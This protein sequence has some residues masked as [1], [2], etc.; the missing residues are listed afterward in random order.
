MSFHF[1]LI[2][3]KWGLQCRFML[4]SFNYFNWVNKMQFVKMNQHIY[5]NLNVKSEF[6]SLNFTETFIWN[7]LQRRNMLGRML[8]GRLFM[9]ILSIYLFFFCETKHVF[10]LFRMW[11]CA[12]WA[13][14]KWSHSLK[15]MKRYM[16]PKYSKSSIDRKSIFFMSLDRWLLRFAESNIRTE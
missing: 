4:W 6:F 9:P 10:F 15:C 13:R 7:L 8:Y 2:R 1:R 5:E 12:L 3:L 11:V 16:V 14:N